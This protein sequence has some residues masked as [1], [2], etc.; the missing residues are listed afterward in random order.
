MSN[1][2][3]DGESRHF[4]ASQK[5]RHRKQGIL[6]ISSMKKK[7]SKKRIS[8]GVHVK[9]LKRYTFAIARLTL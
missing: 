7:P 6:Q 3:R 9:V 4:S 2:T 1:R 8:W 5:L